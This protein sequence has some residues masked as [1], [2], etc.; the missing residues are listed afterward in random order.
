M[1][2]KIEIKPAIWIG[3]V[4]YSTLK[5]AKIAKLQQILPDGIGSRE[6][7]ARAIMENA[8]D[9][10]EVLTTHPETAPAPKRK[11]VRKIKSVAAEPAR[12]KSDATRF[13]RTENHVE[14]GG[15]NA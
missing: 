9:V 8:G 3:E 6:D 14:A 2:D 5:A 13:P 7:A 1:S 12:L 11:Y 15:T 10:A 4:I